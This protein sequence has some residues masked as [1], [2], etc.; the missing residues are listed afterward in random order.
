MNKDINVYGVTTITANKIVTVVEGADLN[1]KNTV[2]LHLFWKH[3]QVSHNITKEILM[4]NW[5]KSDVEHFKQE[6]QSKYKQNKRSVASTN[7]NIIGKTREAERQNKPEM[8][9]A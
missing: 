1:E 9:Q 5:K 2:L 8:R 6:M 7:N 4:K 3:T